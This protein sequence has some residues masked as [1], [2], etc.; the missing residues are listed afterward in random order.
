[1]PAATPGLLVVTPV[2]VG[3]RDTIAPIASTRGVTPVPAL[4]SRLIRSCQLEKDVFALKVSVETRARSS[5]W[6]PWEVRRKPLSYDAHRP[7]T[8]QLLRWPALVRP[9]ASTSTNVPSGVVASQDGTSSV[10]S[11]SGELHGDVHRPTS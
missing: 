8:S 7:S 10:K 9:R 4:R 1:M 11:K 2:E 3:I 6:E 5:V